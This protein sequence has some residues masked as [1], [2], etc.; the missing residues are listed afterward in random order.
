MMTMKR[1]ASLVLIS[2]ITVPCSI[3]GFVPATSKRL[4]VWK[5][6]AIHEDKDKGADGTKAITK[7]KTDIIDILLDNR[8]LNDDSDDDTARSQFGTRQYWDDVY[9]GRGDFPA[10]EYSW[11]FGWEILE[12]YVKEYI[13]T[14]TDNSATGGSS[15]VHILCPGVGNDRILVDLYR[16]KLCTRITAFD[17]SEH[18]IE[19][20]RDL[21]SFELPAKTKTTIDNDIIDLHTMDAR[22]LPNPDWNE[23]FDAVIEK[24]A[25]DAIYLSGDGNVERAVAELGRVLKPGGIFL[26]ISGVVP[27]E[28]RKELFQE[29][30][31]IKDGSDELQAGCFVL[32]KPKPE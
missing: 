23:R 12:S 8:P 31:W 15:P 14:V 11:Y 18:A 17:Y 28:L 1:R 32:K 29:W 5:T 3:A 7:T 30:E 27:P 25:L 4:Q 2:S 24:G 21:L 10:E 13:P 22:K 20:Q 16:S 26:S 9:L 6:S 19:R